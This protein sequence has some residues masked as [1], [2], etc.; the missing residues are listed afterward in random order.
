METDE[1]G[2]QRRRQ[3]LPGLEN[4]RREDAQL[5]RFD[6][7]SALA[8]E[9]GNEGGRILLAHRRVETHPALQQLLDAALSP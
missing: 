5:L 1:S 7:V 9:G 3:L 8:K 4:M 6:A 2:A